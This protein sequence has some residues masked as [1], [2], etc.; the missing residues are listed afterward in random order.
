MSA[1]DGLRIEMYK[2][3]YSDDLWYLEVF[4]ETASKYNAV[5][6]LRKH[7]GFDKIV[8]FGDNLNDIPLFAA[9]DECYAVA[10]AKPEVK[11][12]AT[13]IIGSNNADGV[14]RWLDENVAGGLSEL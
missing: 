4:S 13:G 5:Q 10:N 6:Y 7:C 8:G 1:I 2:D 12:I 9:C 3:I 14:A 11:E